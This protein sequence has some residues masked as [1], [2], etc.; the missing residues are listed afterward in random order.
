MI[1]RRLG[2]S[3]LQVSVFSFGSWITFGKQVGDS[4]AD[5]MMSIAYDSGVNFFDNAEIYS[6]GRSESVMGDILKRKKWD[7]TSYVVSTKVFFGD[8]RRGPN[9]TGLSRKHIME[10]IDASLKRL[11]LDYV[12]LYFCHRPD[13]S[14]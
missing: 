6:R 4:T 9:Q 10:G 13:R 8:G 1:Y 3:G 7:R 11:Q 5:E 2:R 14:E 12:D